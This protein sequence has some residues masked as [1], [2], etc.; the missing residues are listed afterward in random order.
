MSANERSTATVDTG[1]CPVSY[2]F[3]IAPR[4]FRTAK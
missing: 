1:Y 3:R 2:T 4:D